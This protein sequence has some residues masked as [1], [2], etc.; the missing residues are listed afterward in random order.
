M[1]RF[2]VVF[3]LCTMPLFSQSNSGELRLRVTDPAGLGVRT[4]VQIVSQA[5][6]YR[7]TFDHQRP[8]P[9]G[10]AAPAVRHLPA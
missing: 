7:N 8:G 1:S 6:Q 10:R 5:N 2:A 3:F 4:T 9:I